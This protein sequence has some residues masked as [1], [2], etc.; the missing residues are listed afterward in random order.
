MKHTYTINGLQC[1]DCEKKVVNVLMAFSQIQSATLSGNQ[2]RV[3]LNSH[4]DIDELN[5]ALSVVGEYRLSGE[6]MMTEAI[7]KK[8]KSKMSDFVPLVVILVLIV[9]FTVYM[10]WSNN[11]DYEYAMRMFMGAFFGVFGVFKLVNLKNF[12]IAFREYDVLAMK[13]WLYAYLYP[14]IEIGLSVLYILNLGGFYRDIF[15][16]VLMVIGS[17]GVYIKLKKKE[18]VS[19]ACLGL[20]FKFPMTWVTL[21]ENTLMGFMA[22]LMIVM[23]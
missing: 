5:Q 1:Q 23:G 13:S 2:V 12:A 15:V 19:C 8:N 7:V 20:V 11:G 17:Y 4:V 3:I 16:M 14:F 9:F 22:L 10:V 6:E 21:G 18:V